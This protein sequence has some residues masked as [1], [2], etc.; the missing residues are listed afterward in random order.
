MVGLWVIDK[1]INIMF[2]KP[3]TKI[4]KSNHLYSAHS[5]CRALPIFS[6]GSVEGCPSVHLWFYNKLF[7]LK[8]VSPFVKH[9]DFVMFLA[10]AAQSMKIW[11]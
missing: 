7:R 8:D 1:G 11:A 2:T 5:E 9:M 4:S 3:V 6:D 10:G